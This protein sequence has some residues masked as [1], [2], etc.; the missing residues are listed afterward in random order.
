MKAIEQGFFELSAVSYVYAIKN[1]FIKS[2]DET[3]A[4]VWSSIY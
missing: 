2:T 1:V 3:Q 4:G